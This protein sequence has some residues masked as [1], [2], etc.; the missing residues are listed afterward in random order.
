MERSSCLL[1]RIDLNINT[2]L[3][4]FLVLLLRVVLRCM[5]SH[6]PVGDVIRILA[7]FV[8]L[9]RIVRLSKILLLSS[10]RVVY[11]LNGLPWRLFFRRISTRSILLSS[12]PVLQWLHQLCHASCCGSLL[13]CYSGFYGSSLCSSA[14]SL[15]YGSWT[16]MV[17]SALA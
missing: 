17:L 7:I 6:G 4:P 10:R 13:V 9:L 14:C 3:F 5:N 8:L 16:P 15:C 2:F 11:C 1:L 12:L